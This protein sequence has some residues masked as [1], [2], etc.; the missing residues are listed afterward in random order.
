MED[1]Q[2]F[3]GRSMRLSRHKAGTWQFGKHESLC[4]TTNLYQA[5]RNPYSDASFNRLSISL[6]TI[7]SG[8]GF[9]ATSAL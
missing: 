1:S 9:R 8:F 4:V 6:R 2:T 3:C 7:L 5:G